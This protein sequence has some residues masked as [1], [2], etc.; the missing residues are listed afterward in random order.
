MDGME[1]VVYVAVV[2][3]TATFVRIDRI[4]GSHLIFCYATELWPNG[5]IAREVVP[6]PPACA[7]VA[8]VGRVILYLPTQVA[9]VYA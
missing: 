4:T 7:D 8:W 6:H 2:Q 9:N 5:P 1:A 3:S